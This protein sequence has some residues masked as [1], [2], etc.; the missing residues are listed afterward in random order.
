MCQSAPHF[1]SAHMMG[2]EHEEAGSA[3]T[4]AAVG[5]NTAGGKAHAVSAHGR[6][7]GVYGGCQAQ[8]GGWAR[9]VEYLKVEV[10]LLK[11]FLSQS[12]MPL[13]HSGTGNSG[14]EPESQPERSSGIWRRPSVDSLDAN[15]VEGSGGKEHDAEKVGLVR[16]RGEM[17]KETY[18]RRVARSNKDLYLPQGYATDILPR[19]SLT[20]LELL[21]V[22]AAQRRSLAP[23]T[24]DQ[25]CGE[26]ELKTASNQ[27]AAYKAGS[28]EGHLAYGEC[29][30]LMGSH[31]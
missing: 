5:G 12:S 9:T 28:E 30:T 26:N 25:R 3:C 21:R 8:G 24:K 6:E 1:E 20:T 15:G 2:V 14:P 4:E 16:V 22:V 11:Q 7:A 23:K 29:A 31:V 19:P 27:Q 10:H 18:P 13:N 17:K